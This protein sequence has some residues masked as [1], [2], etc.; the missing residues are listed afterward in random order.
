MHVFVSSVSEIKVYIY[1]YNIYNVYIY[2]QWSPQF[3]YLIHGTLQ[4]NI[5]CGAVDWQFLVSRRWHL[6][7]SH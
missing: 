7:M 1:I 3:V 2:Y 5:M 4:P 6:L